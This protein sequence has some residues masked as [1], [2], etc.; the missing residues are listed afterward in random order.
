MGKA[1]GGEVSQQERV[2]EAIIARIR[3][4]YSVVLC[5]AVPKKKDPDGV[6]KK[7]IKKQCAGASHKAL[8]AKSVLKKAGLEHPGDCEDELRR[9]RDEG[10]LACTNGMW[11]ER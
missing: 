5:K 10:V 3:K 9:M 7:A 2:R 4:G 6:G 1:E 8:L 11:W